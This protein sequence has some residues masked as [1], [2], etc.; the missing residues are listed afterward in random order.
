MIEGDVLYIHGF[1]SNGKADR[2]SLDLTLEGSLSSGRGFLNFAF[3]IVGVIMMV[4]QA[5]LMVE[6]ATHLKKA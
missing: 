6:K 1:N 3:I 2:V 4:T 5:Y